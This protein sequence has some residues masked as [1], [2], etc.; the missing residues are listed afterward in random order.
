MSEGQDK[1]SGPDLAAGVQLAQLADGG[2]LLGRVGDEPVL[3]A[4]RGEDI[5]AVAA[6]CT[7][8]GGP[9]ADGLLVGETIRCPWHHACF[10]LRTGVAMRPPALNPIACWRVERQRGMV[11]VREKREPA[12]R[13]A[14]LLVAGEPRSIVIV[15]GGAAGNGAAETLRQEGYTGRITMLSAD[16][17][18]PYDR[19]NLSKDYLAGNAAEEWI[20]LRS[21]EFYREHD[22]ELRLD[23]R[24]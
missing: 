1:P 17:S 16:Q 12:P 9:L 24:A 2:L 21:P 11:Y 3:L 6:I 4:R 22:I 23:A 15:G 18:A 5:F 8:Y 10:D 20:P 13:A 14:P 19:P 7:H